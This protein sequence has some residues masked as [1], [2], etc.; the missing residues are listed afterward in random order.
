MMLSKSKYIQNLLNESLRNH[1]Q[2]TVYKR[3][4]DALVPSIKQFATKTVVGGVGKC[5][6]HS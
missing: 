6:T 5:S 1:K 2:E 4:K 3:Y